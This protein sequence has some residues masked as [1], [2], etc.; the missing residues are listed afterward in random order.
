MG[1]TMLTWLNLNIHMKTTLHQTKQSCSG[2]FFFLRHTCSTHVEWKNKKHHEI[3]FHGVYVILRQ[4]RFLKYDNIF[5]GTD[6]SQD[7]RGREGIVF[8][9]T[10]SLPPPHKHWDIY[11][12]T[13][14]ERWLSRIFNRKASVYQISTQWDL[15][16]Y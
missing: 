5:T 6:D 8:Y 15:P 12:A 11:F 7:I 2:Q 14:H 13:L 9:P 4:F 10:L 3:L 16:P 1:H